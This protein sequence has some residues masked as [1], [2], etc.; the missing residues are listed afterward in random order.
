MAGFGEN[1]RLRRRAFSCFF[2]PDFCSSISA[3]KRSSVCLSDHATVIFSKSCYKYFGVFT[4]VEVCVILFARC[5]LIMLFVEYKTRV[6][7]AIIEMLR[8]F[9]GK[10]V[11]NVGVSMKKKHCGSCYESLLNKI[12]CSPRLDSFR[13]FILFI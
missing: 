7:A 10:Q 6:Y 4:A 12:F 2:I 9:A 8:W 11:R 13:E 5:I 1:V 3:A